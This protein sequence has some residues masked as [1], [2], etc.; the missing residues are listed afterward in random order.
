MQDFQKLKV[1]TIVHKVNIYPF[2]LI[3]ICICRDMIL[4][5]NIQPVKG[6]NTLCAMVYDMK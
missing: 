6:E 4:K 5:V 1:F 3:I 2:G